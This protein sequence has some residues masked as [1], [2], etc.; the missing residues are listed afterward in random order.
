MCLF[1]LQGCWDNKHSYF[2][3]NMS[4]NWQYLCVYYYPISYIMEGTTHV[5]GYREVVSEINWTTP[6]VSW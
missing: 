3:A 6:K 2:W 5:I 1:W 4:E